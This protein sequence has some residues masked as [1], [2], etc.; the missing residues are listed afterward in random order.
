[1][2]VASP[3]DV[4]DVTSELQRLSDETANTSM[5]T[6]WQSPE[7]ASRMVAVVYTEDDSGVSVAQ[8]VAEEH[9]LALIQADHLL[10]ECVKFSYDPQKQSDAA[11]S[12]PEREVRPWQ[13]LF[14][15]I[16]LFMPGAD[17]ES[18]PNADH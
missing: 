15:S 14:R 9:N 18:H 1:M 11:A 12:M 5:S 7:R 4:V 13:R 8:R 2:S 16:R 3:I 6:T 17:T 10:D